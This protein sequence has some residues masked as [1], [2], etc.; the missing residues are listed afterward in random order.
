MTRPTKASRRELK[1]KRKDKGDLE[2]VE[3]EGA[4]VGPWGNWEGDGELPPELQ[5]IEDEPVDEAE[6]KAN[7]E[8]EAARKK[9]AAARR[10]TFG[11]ETSIF[12]GKSLTD[13]QGRTYMHPPLAVAPHLTT[14]PGEQECFIPKSCVHTFTGHTA[15]VSVIRTF[16]GTGHLMLSGSMDKKIKVSVCQSLITHSLLTGMHSFG[17]YIK[18][19]TV[20]GRSMV[21]T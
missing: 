4:Y 6:E 17:T 10:S 8:A 9:S 11:Q 20:Y 19:G 14:D 15:G 5:N 18:K 12:H 2:V 16:P 3:G 13:Y 21:I 1:R 7:E